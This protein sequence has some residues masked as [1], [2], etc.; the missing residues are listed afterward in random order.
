[1][2]ERHGVAVLMK[3]PAR[4]AQRR[5]TNL[6]RYGA[7][8]VMQ[9]K[10]VR[11]K[12]QSTLQSRYGVNHISEIPGVL[13][14]ADATRTTNGTQGGDSQKKIVTCQSNYGTDW[15]MQNPGVF[16]RNLTACFKHKTYT[17]PSGA[18][19]FL[20]GYE[21]YVLTH[22][23]SNGYKEHEFLWQNRPAF[24]Y[25]DKNGE[26]HWYH[27]DFVLPDHKLVVEVKARKWFERDRDSIV[28][29]ATACQHAGW[30]FTIAVMGN[31]IKKKGDNPIEFI[32]YRFLQK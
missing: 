22:M 13:E 17:L 11:K 15:P 30:E 25:L 18:L 14:R 9:S 29:K 28:R 1:M 2:I 27:P 20:Q 21:P 23:L 16:Q 8:Q 32:P 10:K 5:Q 19:I 6:S 7:E 12:Y 3:D 4:D 24:R 31:R 26:S